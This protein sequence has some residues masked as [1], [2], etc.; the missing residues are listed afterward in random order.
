MIAERSRK[1]VNNLKYLR[2]LSGLSTR[3]LSERTGIVFSTISLLEKEQRPFRQVHI[4]RLTSFFDVTVDFLLGRSDVGIYVYPQYGDEK[5]LF[6]LEE[7]KNLESQIDTR[8]IARKVAFT[9]K[10]TGKTEEF[11]IETPTCVYREIK[12]NASDYETSETLIESVNSLMKKMSTDDLKKTKK[13][14]EDYI[15]K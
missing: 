7:Y 13:F 14:I 12:G 9:G 3:E 11:F 6:T 2:A 8:I 1:P 15:I 4:D 10:I 5:L